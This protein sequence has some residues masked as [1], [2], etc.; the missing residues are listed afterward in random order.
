MIQHMTSVVLM[1]LCTPHN[2]QVNDSESVMIGDCDCDCIFRCC[3]QCGYGKLKQ[4][5]IDN[6]ATYNFRQYITWHQW[7]ADMD[8]ETG[9]LVYYA[10]VCFRDTA[11]KL[12][13]LFS[14][15]VMTMSTHLFHFRWQAAQFE[16]I[17]QSITLQEALMV[18]DFA[19]NYEI[20]HADEPQSSHWHHK[21]VT[22]HPVVTYFACPD[23]E[24][25]RK[26]DLIMMSDDKEHDTHAVKAFEDTAVGYL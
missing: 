25:P 1:T 14:E 13:D 10:K 11:F 3:K 6:N 20:R 19:Q 23:C 15:K 26:M 22:L 2:S 9:R 5:I 8:P 21:Q 18:M 24:K 7:R 16:V 4:Q 12:L 17:R